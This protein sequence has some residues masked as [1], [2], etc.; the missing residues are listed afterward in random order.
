V[1]KAPQPHDLSLPLRSAHG[2]D[3]D[4]DSAALVACTMQPYADIDTASDAGKNRSFGR[5]F[6]CLYHQ[7]KQ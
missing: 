3:P 4:G 6:A 1:S 7:P 2:D 5:S